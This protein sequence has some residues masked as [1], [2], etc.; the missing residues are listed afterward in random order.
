M[1]GGLRDFRWVLEGEPKLISYQS[2]SASFFLMSP[3]VCTPIL[4]SSATLEKQ[5][6]E[7]Q[8]LN[9]MSYNINLY[10]LKIIMT[11]KNESTTPQSVN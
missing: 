2:R 3:T 11:N 1:T 8:K 9:F 4:Y 10:N 7:K 6:L 5:K